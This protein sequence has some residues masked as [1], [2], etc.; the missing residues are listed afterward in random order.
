M[1]CSLDAIKAAGG[2]E[3]LAE[4]RREL[5]IEVIDSPGAE[6]AP[7]P[8]DSFSSLKVLP[9]WLLEALQEDCRTETTALEAQVL[10]AVLSGR[11]VVAISPAG[12]THEAY[13]YLLAAAL[14]A[15]DQTAL[16]DEEPGPIVMV[17]SATEDAAVSSCEA[18]TNLFR[19]A[20]KSKNA[21][22]QDGLRAV[23]LSGGG[24]RSDKLQLL[25]ST[26]S[27]IVVGTPKRLHDMASKEQISLL[28]VTMLVI[29]GA[30]RMLE[31]GFLKEVREL[32]SWIRPERQTL[33]MSSTWPRPLMELAGELCDAS[34]PYVRVILSG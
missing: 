31:L 10:P 32:A 33:I 17:I 27:Q 7:P 3:V 15:E 21:K 12:L 8:S 22:L 2:V 5:G 23:C 29:D 25:G 20:S 11:N 16:T 24:N 18:A 26:G 6:E 4:R 14:Q 28:R 19:F 13:L 9:P 30:D 1:T 34:G